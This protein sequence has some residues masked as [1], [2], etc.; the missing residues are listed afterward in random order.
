MI[1]VSS[2][3]LK[4]SEPISAK[5]EG[6]AALLP[7]KQIIEDRLVS[8]P[9]TEPI[10]QAN[11]EQTNVAIVEVDRIASEGT[12]PSHRYALVLQPDE[13]VFGSR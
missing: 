8:P 11:G 1:R 9:T 2:I 7:R 3:V 6:S 5:K 13:V 10:V 4:G 12:A